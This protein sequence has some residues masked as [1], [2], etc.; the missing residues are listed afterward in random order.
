MKRLALA[1]LLVTTVGA[2]VFLALHRPGAQAG[3]DSAM[4]AS[5]DDLEEFLD[6]CPTLDPVYEQIRSDFDI[7]RNGVLAE[8]IPCSEPIS[9][10]P[11]SE[12]S[13]ELITL[14]GLRAIYYMDFG[15]SG[16]LPWTSGTLYEWMQSKI[17][18]IN[19]SDTAGASYCCQ[20]YDDSSHIV[21]TAQDDFNRD[22]DRTWQGISGNIG[23]YMHET[24]HVDGF[25]HVSGC[26]IQDG[27][28]QTYDETDLSPYGIDWWLNAHWL[29]GE[30]YVG[31]SCLDS[32]NVEEIA[33]W[34]LSSAN[35]GRERFVDTKPPELTMPE[36]PG[37]LCIDTQTPSPTPTPTPTPTATATPPPPVGPAR[38]LT[39]NPGWQNAT[40]S[41]ASTPEEVFACA[42]GKYAA[43]YRFVE[44]GLERYFPDRPDIS[45]MNPL[46]Q[47]AA[48][49]IL[50]TQPATCTM[51]VASASG[52][53]RTLQW[54]VGWHNEGWSGADGTAPQDAF[55]CAV[56]NYAAA[57]RLVNGNWERYFPG[58]PDIS[59]MGPL[60][61]Y[62]AFLILVTAP[63]SCTV[64][65]AP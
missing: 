56:G 65:V 36:N 62:D 61:K 37:G 52:A 9:G 60:N 49:L 34:H 26:G 54:G 1:L 64:P 41:G 51:P 28:D 29:T 21:V 19:I 24:R 32:S 33:Q 53:T 7:R 30:L 11:V 18:G 45:N 63:V 50:I 23:L 59:N 25:P 14:Q 8:D 10:L 57:Y 38:T 20:T 40:W 22:F 43:A 17:G 13:D 48:F 35:Y 16:H 3:P 6:T 42:A 27:C 47:Y 58:R 31:F 12:Y 4:T 15:R 39:W 2:G 46:G 44:G 55:A 5:I